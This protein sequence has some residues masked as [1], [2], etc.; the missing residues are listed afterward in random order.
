MNE[1]TP[2]AFTTTQQI[3]AIIFFYSNNPEPKVPFTMRS[4]LL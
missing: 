3:D 1:R 4:S 2:K